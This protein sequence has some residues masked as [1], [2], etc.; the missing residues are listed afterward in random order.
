MTQLPASLQL[1]DSDYTRHVNSDY[2]RSRATLLS[3]LEEGKEAITLA[4]EVA[5][6]TEHP[7]AI[8][9][10]SGLMKNVAD[11]NDK[12]MELN[13]K[14]KEFYERK[15]HRD[16]PDGPASPQIT[17]HNYLF[18]GTVADLQKKLAEMDGS[19]SMIDITPDE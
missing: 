8:E 12:L 19:S 2:E 9:V 13:K 16:A 10:L 7:R 11:I 3:L 4:M 5:R 1:K 6:S 18:T 15:S 14:N 17:N